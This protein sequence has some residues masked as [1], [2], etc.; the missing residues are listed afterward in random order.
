VLDVSDECAKG[1][2]GYTCTGGVGERA[3]L[4]TVADGEELESQPVGEVERLPV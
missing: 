1:L 3:D 4:A 2:G